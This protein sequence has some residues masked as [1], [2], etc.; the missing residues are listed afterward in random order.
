[1]IIYCRYGAPYLSPCPGFDL[2]LPFLPRSISSSTAWGWPWSTPSRSRWG[3]SPPPQLYL[4]QPVITERRGSFSDG[5]TLFLVVS[6]QCLQGTHGHLHRLQS[7]H[8]C[9]PVTTILKEG[10]IVA[11]NFPWL[12]CGDHKIFPKSP[13]WEGLA[14]LII[15]LSWWSSYHFNITFCFT[16]SKLVTLATF[17]HVWLLLNKEIFKRQISIKYEKFWPKGPTFCPFSSFFCTLTLFSFNIQQGRSTSCCIY[18]FFG[19]IRLT[20]GELVS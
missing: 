1:M 19:Q 15:I 11:S 13:V 9:W 2:S 20:R 7:V 16:I 3:T 10:R 17:P 6:E 18:V 14:E 12:G 5:P 8:P 4:G